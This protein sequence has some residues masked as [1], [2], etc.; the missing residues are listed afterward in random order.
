MKNRILALGGLVAVLG[1][2]TAY[3]VLAQQ[4]NAPTPIPGAG[5]NGKG[6]EKHPELKK[7]MHNLE[8]AKSNLQKA[9]R[10]FGGHRAKAAELT[11]EAIKEVQAAIQADKN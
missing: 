11:D 3:G 10:D 1:T 8:Q 5:Q 4:S 6:R 7:A 9:A 2:T